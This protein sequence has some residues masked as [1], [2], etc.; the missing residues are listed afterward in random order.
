MP[1]LPEV[2]IWRETLEGWLGGRK[3][4]K[5]SVPDPILRGGQSRAKVE[6]AL[7]GATI[8]A[9]GRRGKFLLFDLGARRPAVLVHLGMT[10][11]FERVGKDAPLPKF[12]RAVLSLSR[13]ERVAF[14]DTRRLGEFRLVLDKEQKRLD[15]LGVEPLTRAFTATRLHALTSRSKRP[16]KIFLL[17]QHKIAGIGNIHAAEALFLAGIHPVLP[18][19]ELSID[20]TR[21][22]AAAIRQELR[23][24]LK[25]SR[26]GKL[27]YLQQGGENRF[28]IY[29]HLGEPCPKCHSKI[30][31]IVQGGRST[32]YCPSCQP[33][34]TTRR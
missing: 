32:Y 10:G 8:G 27:R 33:D 24:E 12:S 25:R 11:A 6:K 34:A 30:G 1:E 21:A 5:A 20:Q 14:L 16:I 22:L 19:S 29:G 28:R 4:R 18:A 23:G 17:D 2:E 31:R 13:E 3:I 9:V 7:E 26:D 15:A